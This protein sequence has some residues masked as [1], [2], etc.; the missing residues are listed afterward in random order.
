MVFGLLGTSGHVAQS[1]QDFRN[2]AVMESSQKIAQSVGV[3]YFS[4]SFSD[5]LN[6]LPELSGKQILTVAPPVGPTRDMLKLL[7]KRLSN[8]DIRLNQ[9]HRSYD[10]I[11]WP[12][13][14]AGFF[15]LKTKIPMVLQQ[16][17]LADP[18][19][20]RLAL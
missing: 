14:F 6:L 12:H 8:H 4:G 9:H 20:H 3:P 11:T 1:V 17:G 16:L 15:K 5:L 7:E 2:R 13:A 18:V 19:Q 10:R